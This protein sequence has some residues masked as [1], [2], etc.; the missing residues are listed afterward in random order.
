MIYTGFLADEILAQDSPVPYV[1]YLHV[2]K[3]TG[4]IHIGICLAN[5]AKENMFMA[6]GWNGMGHGMYLV[7]NDGFVLSS[8][9][10]NMDDKRIY[11]Y[12]PISTG[13]TIK[14]KY[15]PK[16]GTLTISPR[17]AEEFVMK[18]PPPP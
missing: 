18:V 17:A 4:S 15:D 9:D 6:I 12:H 13:H 10:A 8:T 5:K 1:W 7:K 14:L 11:P 2:I 16:A 3:R